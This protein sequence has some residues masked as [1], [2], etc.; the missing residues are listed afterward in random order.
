MEL[1]IAGDFYFNE[2]YSNST[3]LSEDLVRLFSQ[4]T[5][6][7]LNLEAPITALDKRHA[8]PKTGPNLKME[9]ATAISM[10]KKLDINAVTLANNHIMDY[11]ANALQ[12]TINACKAN[13]IAYVGAGMENLEIKTPITINDDSGKIA[14]LNF[15]E[16]EWTSSNSTISAA[17]SL[18]I[19]ENSRQIKEAKKNHDVVIVIIHGG[20]EYYSL[21]SPR[22]VKQYRFYA[23]AGASV[24]VGHHPHCISGYEVH[25]GVPI[26]YSIGN[27]LFTIPSQFKAWYTGLLL[28]LSVSNDLKL[29][30]ELIPIQQSEETFSVSLLKQEERQKILDEVEQLSKIIADEK[31]LEKMWQQFVGKQQEFYLS[32]FSPANIFSSR[33]IKAG[34][35]YTRLNK[36]FIRKK[37]YRLILN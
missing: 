16:N 34:L 26:F 13:N 27:F 4:S 35:R 17:N 8:I 22:M 24:I 3:I 28:K 20:H 33:Y 21:P 32:S 7:I 2:K 23:E 9:K 30:W 31:E 15:A 12:D 36:L 25:Q 11:G 5:Y 19:I 18:D 10:L 29:N 37:Q 14:V 6:K 1:L